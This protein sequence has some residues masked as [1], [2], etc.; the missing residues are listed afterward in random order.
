MHTAHPSK[1]RNSQAGV[2]FIHLRRVRFWLGFFV[3]GLVISGVTAIPLQTEAN[4]LAQL[5][6]INSVPRAEWNML[7]KWL[8]TVQ[9][10]LNETG[11]RF[12]FLYYGTDWLAFGHL[13]IALVFAGPW[14]DPVRNKW[15]I[16]FGVIACLLVIPFALVFGA[17]RGIPFF[18][19]L[20]DC[21]FGVFGIIPL[22]ITLRA[23][24]KHEVCVAAASPWPNT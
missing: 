4:A 10:G 1:L 19:R 24:K 22:W 5:F 21:S 14:I 12:P 20:I 13:M 9:I 17:I 3:F 15:V 11:Y 16:H 2:P 7:Q 23:I 18:W 8:H 6:G